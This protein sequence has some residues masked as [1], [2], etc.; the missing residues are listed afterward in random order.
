[1]QCASPSFADSDDS[2]CLSGLQADVED[3]KSAV[4]RHK[5]VLVEKDREMVRKVQSAHEEEFHKTAT[6]HEEKWE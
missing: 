6:L 4:E 1:M 3:L 2:L 5:G